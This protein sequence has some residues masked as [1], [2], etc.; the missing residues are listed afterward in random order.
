MSTEARRAL[1]VELTRPLVDSWWTVVAGV[2]LGLA[3]GMVALRYVSPPPDGPGQL[4]VIAL[5][6]VIGLMLFVGPPVVRSA[7]NPVISSER[8]MRGLT[9]V[10]LLVGIPRVSTQ[11]TREAARRRKLLNTFLSFLATTVLV[12][13]ALVIRT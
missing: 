3:A 8:T 10:P 7:V 11:D 13:T 1:A 12:V 5:G 6:L 2:C 9:D 4:Q